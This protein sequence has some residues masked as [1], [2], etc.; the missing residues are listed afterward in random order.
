MHSRIK[1]FIF[2]IHDIFC[3]IDMKSQYLLPIKQIDRGKDHYFIIILYFY[4]ERINLINKRINAEKE[5]IFELKFSIKLKTVENSVFEQHSSI[6]GADK[7]L[8]MTKLLSVI[9]YSFEEIIFIA[10]FGLVMTY[11]FDF[12]ITQMSLLNTQITNLMSVL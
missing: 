11:F 1:K 8:V 7:D 9:L 4:F 10:F 3:C 6:I 2:F 5:K 12:H